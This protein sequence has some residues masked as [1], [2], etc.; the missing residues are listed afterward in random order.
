MVGPATTNRIIG[1]VGVSHLLFVLAMVLFAIFLSGDGLSSHVKKEK[2]I[3]GA[4]SL[5]PAVRPA[6]AFRS[7]ARG[8]LYGAQPSRADPRAPIASE[9][10]LMS[11][12][13]IN[14]LD[15]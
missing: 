2:T 13:H 3:S 7:L 11:N 5:D 15:S 9:L 10:Q 6:S 14:D 8:I 12:E 4:S 1:G